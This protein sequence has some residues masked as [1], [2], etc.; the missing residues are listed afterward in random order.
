MPARAPPLPAFI[1]RR[2]IAP[3]RPCETQSIECRWRQAQRLGRACL[4]GS[5]ESV[6]FR[7]LQLDLNPPLPAGDQFA[8]RILA[9]FHPS[10]LQLDQSILSAG[11]PVQQTSPSAR[12]LPIGQRSGQRPAHR[13]G[14]IHQLQARVARVE[15]RHLHAQAALFARA[16]KPIETYTVEPWMRIMARVFRLQC[17]V[18]VGSLCCADLPRQSCVE[19]RPSHLKLRVLLQ[20]QSQKLCAIPFL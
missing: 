18:G 16:Q 19:L 13:P 11:K 2:W 7:L 17:H 3:V 10:L 1:H 20:R 12:T 8:R 4:C 6:Q 9:D 15:L 14:M 5:G